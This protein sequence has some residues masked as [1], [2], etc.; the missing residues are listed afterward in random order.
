MPARS[1]SCAM[2]GENGVLRC[3]R[4]VSGSTTS[5]FSTAAISGLRN[6]PCMVRWR[7]KRELRRLGVERLAV[8]ELDVRAQLDRHRLAVVGG[9]V[10]QREL[11]HDVELLVDVEELV[12]ER[13]EDDASDIGAGER[14]V[15]HVGILGKP[16]AQRRLRA[17]QSDGGRERRGREERGGEASSHVPL[18]VLFPNCV[19]PEARRAIRDPSPS[20]HAT[21]V[22]APAKAANRRSRRGSTTASTGTISVSFGIVGQKWQAVAWPLP[23]SSSGGRSRRLSSPA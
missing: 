1:V 19:I 3:R 12:A 10:G 14:R 23:S 7:S 18:P 17:R 6:E 11:R 5:T 21:H 4:T 8:V 20:Q 2:S 13:R 9:L 15:E 22:P 16:D